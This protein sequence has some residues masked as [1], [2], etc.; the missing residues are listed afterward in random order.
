MMNKFRGQCVLEMLHSVRFSA[1]LLGMVVMFQAGAVRADTYADDWQSQ[2]KVTTYE[3]ARTDDNASGGSTLWTI[4]NKADVYSKELY[5]RPVASMDETVGSKPASDTYYE[6]IDISTG[7]VA[8]DKVSEHAYFSID[9]TGDAEVSDGSSV[10]KGFSDNYR[11]RFSSNRNFASEDGEV[12]SYMIGVK[13]PSGNVSGS[14]NDS[15]SSAGTQIW[16]D[17][18]SDGAVTG[19]GLSITDEDTSGYAELTSEG[20]SSDIRAR[21]DGNSIQFAL[22]YGNLGL[23]RTS[24][25]I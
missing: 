6:F 12:S 14:F 9:L 17:D 16:F 10:S 21:V 11:I 8:I 15:G 1:F 25:V 22:N 24:F 18:P 5:E 19:T 4:D 3:D 23:E 2:F 13:D 7:S 20:S